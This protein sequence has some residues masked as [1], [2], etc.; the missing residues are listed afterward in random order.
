MW[1]NLILSVCDQR[2]VG[3]R[4]GPSRDPLHRSEP[5]ATSVCRLPQTINRWAAPQA[6]DAH[7]CMPCSGSQ[8]EVW[9]SVDRRSGE[10]CAIKFLRRGPALNTD[11]VT[12]CAANPV[13]VHL[14][15]LAQRF[16]DLSTF[17]ITRRGLGKVF[18]DRVVLHHPRRWSDGGSD[19]GMRCLQQLTPSHA[20]CSALLQ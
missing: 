20:C 3:G 2:R 16:R 14:S 18:D 5:P 8:G 1:H 13:L 15:A 6:A 17:G 12:R 19:C 7:L 11:A 10:V 9:S 4:L